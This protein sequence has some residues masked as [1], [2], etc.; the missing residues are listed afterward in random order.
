MEEKKCEKCVDGVCTCADGSTCECGEDCDCSTCKPA[1]VKEE[2]KEE[3][4]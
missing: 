4:I 3:E 2:E 1:E